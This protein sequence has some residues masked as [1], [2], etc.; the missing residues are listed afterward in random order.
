[1]KKIMFSDKFLLTKAVLEGRKTQTRRLLKL[2]LHKKAARGNALIEVSP[3]KVFFEDGKWKFHK[4]SH[5]Y[6]KLK[7]YGKRKD[8][9]GGN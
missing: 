3:S 9:T 8:R 7:N 2:T 1:M 4:L 6:L 5:F